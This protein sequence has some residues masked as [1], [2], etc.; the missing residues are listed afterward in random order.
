MKV[1]C[2]GLE[3]H[4]STRGKKGAKIC[5]KCGYYGSQIKGGIPF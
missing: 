4:Q 5:I 1:N 3:D 2:F